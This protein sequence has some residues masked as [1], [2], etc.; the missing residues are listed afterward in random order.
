MTTTTK[1]T[2]YYAILGLTP[3]AT[4][5]DLKKAHRRLARQHH[6]DR[7]NSDPGAAEKFRLITEA[8]EYLSAHLKRNANGHTKTDTT[9]P[10]QGASVGMPGGH[11]EAASRVLAVLEEIW[12]AIRVRHPEIPPVVI[13]IASGTGGRDA[14]WGHFDPQRWTVDATGTLAEILISGEGLRRHPRDV[15][16]TL[17]H[18]AA[19]ALAA[20][21]GIKD[22]SRQGRYHNRHYKVL[23]E[24]LG[25][26]V[27]HDSRIG[28]SLTSVP[29]TTADAYARWLVKLHVAMTLWRHDEFKATTGNGSGVRTSNLIAA[30]CPCGRSIRIAVSTLAA[31]P[32][33]CGACDGD[34]TPKESR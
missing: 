7:N 10:P 12:Q 31:A 19:H 15:L 4:L 14:R 18:E 16:G 30:A 22:T 13:I 3:Q 24:E 33:T 27:D 8:Y 21:R 23:A 11:C 2:D 17:L 34:F 26:A 20:A 6:P 28:W 25:L 1:T 29:D 32:V 5:A 9:T